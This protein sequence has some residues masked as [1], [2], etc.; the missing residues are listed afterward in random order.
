MAFKVKDG[1]GKWH[2]VT[3]RRGPN[4]S[5]YKPFYG[6]TKPDPWRPPAP[7]EMP[8]I[9]DTSQ[10]QTRYKSLRSTSSSGYVSLI[11]AYNI[12]IILFNITIWAFNKIRK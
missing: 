3:N 5:W 8:K 7:I 9:R 4:S 1:D 11:V 6:W 2:S 12:C 10:S